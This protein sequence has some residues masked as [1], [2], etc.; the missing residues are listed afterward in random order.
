[1]SQDG[2]I[3]VILFVDDHFGDPAMRRRFTSAVAIL[4]SLIV[5]ALA[6]SACAPS[7]EEIQEEFDEF[8]STRNSCSDVSDC[9]L[10]YPGCPLGCA[11]GVNKAHAADVKAKAEELIED[12]ESGGQACAYECL[13]TEPAC[14]ACR[15]D[16][17]PVTMGS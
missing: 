1:M 17:V 12:Y 15:C 5:C 7:E 14:T 9:A 4:S 2:A 11:V 3:R 8:L 10:V 13:Q 16:A 6:A